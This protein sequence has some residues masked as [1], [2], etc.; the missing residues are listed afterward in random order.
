MKTFLYPGQSTRTIYDGCCRS[1]IDLQNSTKLND[2]FQA[3]YDAKRIRN[4]TLEVDESVIQQQQQQQKV[5]KEKT[6][7]HIKHCKERLQS[8]GD[9][10]RHGLPTMGMIIF[11]INLAQIVVLIGNIRKYM[12]RYDE[13]HKIRSL[14][15]ILSLSLTDAIFGLGAFS[16]GLSNK[17]EK[18]ATLPDFFRILVCGSMSIIS[19]L[20]LIVITCQRFYAVYNPFKYNQNRSPKIYIIVAVAIWVV[21]IMLVVGYYFVLHKNDVAF[22]LALSLISIITFP[23]VAVFLIFYI[24]I[25]YLLRNRSDENSSSSTNTGQEKKILRLAVYIIIC[26]TFCWLPVS[27]FGLYKRYKT[28]DDVEMENRLVLIQLYLF[29]L[30]LVNS[31]I[32]PILYFNFIKTSINKFRRRCFDQ[33]ARCIVGLRRRKENIPLMVNNNRRPKGLEVNQ[34][35]KQDVAV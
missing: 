35:K 22:D 23:A 2:Y 12:K 33:L 32:N 8:G 6:N 29:S 17:D 15:F 3:Y 19:V 13:Q 31:F 5:I 9:F 14:V 16:Y 26:F 30:I 24:W 27:I 28:P 1:L 34:D 10:V 7:H 18:L 4:S 11:L 20:T 25:W 21:S